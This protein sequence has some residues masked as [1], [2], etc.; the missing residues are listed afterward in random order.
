MPTDREKKELM[1]CCVVAPALEQVGR[2][3]VVLERPVFVLSDALGVEE[4]VGLGAAHLL[5]RAHVQLGVVT[6]NPEAW[7]QTRE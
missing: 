1:C 4:D 2:G 3:Q 6:V 5:H 7:G